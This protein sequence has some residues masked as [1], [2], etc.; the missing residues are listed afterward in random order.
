MKFLLVVMGVALVVLFIY[1]C[2]SALKHG[3]QDTYD[4]FN[5][6]EDYEQSNFIKEY[7][8]KKSEKKR[9]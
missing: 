3:N 4:Y 9:K 6:I 2:F 5:A 7:N 8:D 1:I